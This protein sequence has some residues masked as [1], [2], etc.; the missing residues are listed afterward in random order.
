MSEEVRGCT[1]KMKEK[2]MVYCTTHHRPQR[3]SK[4]CD[5]FVLQM[6]SFRAWTPSVV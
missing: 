4:K 6:N 2:R 3:E 5:F 1:S